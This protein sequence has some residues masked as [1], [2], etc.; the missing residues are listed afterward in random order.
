[1]ISYLLT[2]QL[3]PSKYACAGKNYSKL[4]ILYI[5]LLDSL[6]KFD[7]RVVRQYFFYP[8]KVRG[9]SQINSISSIE[10][11]GERGPRPNYQPGPI[12]IDLIRPNKAEGGGGRALVSRANSRMRAIAG[13]IR[14]RLSNPPFDLIVSRF[15][16]ISLVTPTCPNLITRPGHHLIAAKN[17]PS[18]RR[19]ER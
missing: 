10:S 7:P 11:F 9:R 2:I 17:F 15:K 16:V 5:P 1:M 4:Y 13:G 19:R 8:Q 12:G 18:S 3:D 6:Q 14:P